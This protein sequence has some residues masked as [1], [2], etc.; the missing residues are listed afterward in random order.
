[1]KV[2]RK[3]LEALLTATRREQSI[4]GKN[5]PQVSSTVLH[6]TPADSEAIFTANI[7]KDGKTSLSRF[8]FKQEKAADKAT[9]IPVPDIERML[10]VL[11]YHGDMV[12][13]THDS[14]KVRIKSKN[15]Q[16]TLTGGFDAKSYANSQHNLKEAN[17]QAFER[18]KQ[19]KDNVYHLQDGSSI[20]PFYSV[21]LPSQEMY[22]ALRCDGING[23]KLNRYKF[24]SDGA[25]LTVSVGDVFKGMTTTTLVDDYAGKDFDATFEGGLEN[26]FKHY[27]G[28]VKLSFLD[29][30]EY[31]QG[32]RLII[33]FANGDFVLQAG[34]LGV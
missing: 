17:N 14:G 9:I 12:T 11:K 5:Q 27:S 32:I 8:S 34:V 20:A 28:D 15:K 30:T 2:G 25:A 29:F 3:A 16:T 4:N 6:Y 24:A 13:L 23:Q 19:I 18:V 26:I 10:G 7:V 31:G 21:S 22:D 33:N 1:M